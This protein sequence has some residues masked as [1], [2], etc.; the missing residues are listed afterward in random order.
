MSRRSRIL[1]IGG[2]ACG[3][4]AAARAR[5]CD[6][7]AEIT[8]IE[9]GGIVSYASCGLPYY[10]SGI[11]KKRGALLVRTVEDFKKIN[12]IDVL[13][14]SIARS[15][16]R[17]GHR[18]AISNLKSGEATVLEYDKLILA[19]GAR[20]VV[21]NIPGTNLGG[22]YTLKGIPDA[23]EIMSGANLQAGLRA[24]IV[25]AGLIGMEMIEALIERG[26]QVT[27]VESLDW[28]LPTV[29]DQDIALLLGRRLMRR[30]VSLR[31]GE[32]VVGFEGDGGRIRRV[33][34]N[35]TTLEADVVIVAIGVRPNVELAKESGL[36]LGVTGAIAADQYLQ[37]SDPDIYAGGDC[38]ENIHLLGV[39]KVLV[40]MGST[41][42]KH[43]RVIGT[44]VTGGR[45]T[46]PGVLGTAAV[47]IF[48]DNIGRVGLGEKQARD[49]GFDL[50]TALVPAPDHA[51]YYPG[52]HDIL[53]KLIAERG[54][55]RILG[56]Q[57]MG[58]GDVV[59]R[60]D[61]AAAVM[62]FGG[63]VDVLANLDLSYAPPYDSAMDPLHN[64]ANLIRN[65][66]S[67]M[68]QGLTP[69]QVKNKLNSSKDFVL[70]DVR[71]TDEWN[72]WRIE[73]E[74]VKLLPLSRLRG[75][76][77]E[78]VSD[79]E[80]VTVCRRGARAYHAQRILQESGLTNVKFMEG[81]LA[82]WPY[83]VFGAGGD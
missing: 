17:A 54:T 28:P 65:K 37:T 64:A 15:I 3:P 36:E 41:A 31:L 74:Q 43:G 79:N 4:K 8:I 78:L 55:G 48:D 9:Q 32:R 12:N 77:S 53:L 2:G 19:L 59:K 61:V 11:I 10:I 6:P 30:G 13:T 51:H 52:A 14:D 71:E 83:D 40:P 68:A 33:V 44:N 58:R 34:T 25:G 22:I 46:F 5:R 1:V 16:D 24:V 81:S 50:V 39:D 35:K 29:L 66:L 69:I 49:A 67:G 72:R 45:D 21:P 75:R 23:D 82:A 47:K 60:I 27:V 62:T 70:L 26:L 76:V 56:L 20:P 42:N 57:G 73:S 63:T 38:V 80:I 18:V 7:N